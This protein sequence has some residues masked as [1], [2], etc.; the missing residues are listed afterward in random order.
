MIR[1]KPVRTLQTVMYLP[2][3]ISW[4][5]IG[6]IL[7]N[8]LS[9]SY[10]VVNLI[11]QS[12]GGD[13]IY[14]MAE[15]KWFRPLV[16]ISSIWKDS[17][18]NTIIY[19]AAISSIGPELYEAATVDGA[20]KLQKMLHVTLPGI[21]ST[22]VVLLLLKLGQI[23]NNGFDQIFILQNSQN[24]AVSDVFE[25]Y[26][27]RIGMVSGRYSFST[28]VGMFTSVISLTFLIISNKIAK[29]LGEEGLW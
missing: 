2:Y 26:T 8:F 29:L 24:L 13:P 11:I 16:I 15:T 4:V 17:G 22:I 10:G 9:P 1:K 25:T 27:Y 14:F 19:L 18:W 20:N 6:G 7:V 12:L 28:A 5:V 23:M 21:K 3:F